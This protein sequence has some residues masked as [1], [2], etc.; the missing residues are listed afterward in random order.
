MLL[1]LAHTFL[2]SLTFACSPFSCPLVGS[3]HIQCIA[4]GGVSQLNLTQI[5]NFLLPCI[6]LACLCIQTQVHRIVL[7]CLWPLCHTG[8]IDML[9]VH[10]SLVKCFFLLFLVG[11]WRCPQIAL[12]LLNNDWRL[13]NL[14]LELAVVHLVYNIDLRKHWIVLVMHMV[15]YLVGHLLWPSTLVILGLIWD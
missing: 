4:S 2:V 7:A 8:L 10:I 14:V 13:V 9:I 6:R 5:D 11:L 15:H 12:R 1:H 3:T